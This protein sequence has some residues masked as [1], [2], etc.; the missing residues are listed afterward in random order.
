[1][2]QNPSLRPAETNPN[3][4]TAS[5]K[6]SPSA[7]LEIAAEAERLGFTFSEYLESIA[8]SR[9][10]KD[11]LEKIAHLEKR[12]DF[13]EKGPLLTVLQRH[14]GKQYPLSDGRQVRVTSIEDIVTI[15]ADDLLK[16]QPA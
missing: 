9:Q 1:M 11:A 3:K 5:F 10:P 2:T 4:V 7:K 15:L 13:F 14:R 12:L 8:L 16:N 6:C